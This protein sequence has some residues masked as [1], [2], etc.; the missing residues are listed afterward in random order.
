MSRSIAWPAGVLALVVMFGSSLPV[1]A[2]PINVT[3]QTTATL[4]TDDALFFTVAVSGFAADASAF[5]LSPYPAK[6]SFSFVTS[7]PAPGGLFDAVL[8]T[9]GGSVSAPFPDS[10][11][12]EP[13]QYQ[14]TYYSGP[15]GVIEGSLALSPALSAE[16]F[17]G[18]AVVLVLQNLGPAASVGLAPYTLPHDLSVSLSEGGLGAGAPVTQAYLDDPPAPGT[19]PEPAS[20]WLLGLGGLVLCGAAKLRRASHKA[21]ATPVA[22]HGAKRARL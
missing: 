15:V 18:G 19:A 8:E 12:F 14:G 11:Q 22:S 4:P 21:F 20:G 6:V 2:D 7:P 13:G 9:P 10:L 5:G 1:A 17:G 3:T 16:L